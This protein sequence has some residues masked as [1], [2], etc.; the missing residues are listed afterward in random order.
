MTVYELFQCDLDD[1]N[2][3]YNDRPIGLF[4]SK[5]NIVGYMTKDGQSSGRLSIMDHNENDQYIEEYMDS[6]NTIYVVNYGSDENPLLGYSSP[7]YNEYYYV[8]EREVREYGFI[9]PNK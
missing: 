2:H 9:R 4:S 5:E 6:P 3:R 7:E 8:Q 1:R